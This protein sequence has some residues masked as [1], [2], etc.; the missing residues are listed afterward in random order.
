MNQAAESWTIGKVL[1][2]AQDDFAKR[3]LSAPRLDAELLLCECLGLNRVQLI[4]DSSRP[5]T[6]SE[7]GAFRGLI[8]RRR[9]G[10]PIAYILGRREFWGLEFRTDSRA[11]VPRPDTEALVEVAL[12]RTRHLNL[13]GT[14]VDVC[15]GSGCVAIAFHH[16]RPTWHVIGSDLSADALA[17]ARENALRLGSV[18]GMAWQ[19]SDLLEAIPRGV[20]LDLITANAPYIPSSEIPELDVDVRGFEPALALDGGSDGLELIRRL[21]PSA[22]ERLSPG[23]VLALELHHDQA[24]RVEALLVELGFRNTLRKKDYAGHERVVSGQKPD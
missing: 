1:R 14:A 15:T 11:L 13:F 2:W 24:N 7:L 12:E 17:L 3:G 9:G 10:E 18:W 23:G 5:L 8:K 6:A 20:G 4:T 16:E 19:Q 22:L 21:A